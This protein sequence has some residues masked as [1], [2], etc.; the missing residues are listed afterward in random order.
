ME[1]HAGEGAI[2]RDTLRFAHS[3]AYVRAALDQAGLSILSLQAVSTRTEKKI[4]VPGLMAVA[5]RARMTSALIAPSRDGDLLP[6]VFAEWFAKRGWTPRAHQLALI[7]KARTGRSTLLI[8]PTGGGKTLAGFL[9][10]L[11]EL[12]ARRRQIADGWFRPERTSGG[13]KACTRFI[14]RR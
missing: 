6:P 4:P 7:E 13:R 11:T 2:L 14:S 3:E 9:P 1:T 5:R 10:T 12:H 8:A